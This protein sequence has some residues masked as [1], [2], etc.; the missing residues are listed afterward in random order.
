MGHG[1]HL[2]FL[3]PATNVAATYSNAKTLSRPVPRWA[4]LRSDRGFPTDTC[5]R[6][7]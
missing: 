4:G 3:L 2:S 7:S 6:P 1:A 5:G